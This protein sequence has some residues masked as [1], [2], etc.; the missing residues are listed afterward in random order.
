MSRT[1]DN[2]LSHLRGSCSGRRCFVLGNGRSLSETDLRKLKGEVTIGCNGLYLLFDRMGY[3]PTFYMVGDPLVARQSAPKVCNIRDSTKVF[4][5]DLR[6]WLAPDRNTVYFEVDRSQKQP[7]RFSDDLGE[8]GYW[9]GCVLYFALQL[10]WYIGCRDVYLV[11]V[12]QDYR[13]PPRAQF[14]G[15]L[16]LDTDDPCNHFDPN[17]LERCCIREYHLP[18][19]D[20]M[21]RGFEQARE[22]YDSH[23]GRISNATVGGKLEVFSRVSF[24]GLFQ[25]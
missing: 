24:E 17:Y 22:F 20:L 23:G 25:S 5:L 13:L 11:G 21:A 12:D 6:D 7:F 10:A 4:P 3:T 18:R 8:V 1:K 16:R 19:V 2:R 14:E 9:G 15:V